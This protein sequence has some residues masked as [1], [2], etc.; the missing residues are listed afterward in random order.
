MT[1]FYASSTHAEDQAMKNWTTW[2]YISGLT[3]VI[4]QIW[5]AI[6]L[7]TSTPFP[8]CRYNEQCESGSYCNLGRSECTYCSQVVPLPAQH[9]GNDLLNVG[10]NELIAPKFNV[11]LLAELCSNPTDQLACKTKGLTLTECAESR[12]EIQSAATIAFWCEACVNAVD[13][14]VKPITLKALYAANVHAMRLFDWLVLAFASFVASLSVVGELKDIQLCEISI[15]RA[16]GKL[17]G[18]WRFSLKVLCG[19]RRW[20]FLPCLMLTIPRLV[21]LQ[22]GEFER[23]MKDVTIIFA[24]NLRDTATCFF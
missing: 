23:Q 10:H 20:S 16:G 12:L 22:G 2:M 5:T 21:M 7:W 1:I 3:M 9:D 24:S 17:S 18:A 15:Q 14:S 4:F 13:L 11:T 19:I 8:G 6:T